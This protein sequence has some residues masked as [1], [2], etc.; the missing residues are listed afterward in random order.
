MQRPPEL[1]RGIAALHE[2]ARVVKMLDHLG[3]IDQIERFDG[4]TMQNVSISWQLLKA[5][6]RVRLSRIS[7]NRYLTPARNGHSHRG[8]KLLF[9]NNLETHY[10]VAVTTRNGSFDIVNRAVTVTV[11]VT[12]SAT[13]LL[14]LKMVSVFVLMSVLLFH[15]R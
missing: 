13:V 4:Q 3:A 7:P 10:P 12:L 2:A 14:I 15:R 11:P 8:L 1:G 9:I 5:A 6:V